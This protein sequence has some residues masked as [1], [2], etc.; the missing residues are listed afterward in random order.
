MTAPVFPFS[1]NWA[2]GLLE[3]LEWWTQIL[4]GITGKEQ[5]R[6]RRSF[7]RR[8]IEF[9]LLVDGHEA[10]VLDAFLSKYRASPVLMPIW[11]DP[12]RLAAPLGAGATVVPCATV[13][14]DFNDGGQAVLLRNYKEHEAVEI[15]T[16]DADSINLAAPTTLDWARGTRLLPARE[17]LL[18]TRLSHQRRTS[19]VVMGQVQC[20]LTPGASA[21]LESTQYRSHDVLMLRPNWSAGVPVTHDSLVRRVDS[22]VGP[23]FQRDVT[24]EEINLRTLS[25]LLGSRAEIAEW[26]GFLHARSGARRAYYQPQWQHDLI[27]TAAIASSADELTVKSVSYPALYASAPHRRDIALLHR[28]GTWYMRRINAAETVGSNDVLTLDSALGIDADPG[29]CRMITYLS[30]ARLDADAHE[31]A[32]RTAGVATAAFDS[33][34]VQQ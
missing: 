25:L 3:R 4:P 9:A 14:Y 1:P 6:E 2:S 19:A 11:T 18:N 20:Q 21:A 24:G 8:L 31:I 33:R 30:H 13:G 15:D 27:Q 34:T 32:W 5:R 29:D 23:I 10:A 7:P 26:R 12:Q 22:G 17:G 16:V 28:S